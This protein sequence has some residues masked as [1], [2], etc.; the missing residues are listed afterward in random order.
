MTPRDGTRQRLTMRSPGK[1]VACGCLPSGAA[2][3]VAPL[4]VRPAQ[5]RSCGITVTPALLLKCL[6]PGQALS[7]ES[8]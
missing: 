6:P 8:P 7:L 5:Q 3:P 1:S 2:L 4:G